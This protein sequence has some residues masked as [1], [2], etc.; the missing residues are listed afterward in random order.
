MIAQ[1]FNN[2]FMTTEYK[3]YIIASCDNGHMSSMYEPPFISM[4]PLVHQPARCE[5]LTLQW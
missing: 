4:N 1:I 5:P 2:G 3:W